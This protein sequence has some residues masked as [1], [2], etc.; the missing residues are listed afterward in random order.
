MAEIATLGP[1]ALID[2]LA[3][4][5]GIDWSRVMATRND[6]G[7]TALAILQQAY[8]AV[9]GVNQ[10]LIQRY[11]DLLYVT[12]SDTVIYRNTDGTRS[13]TPVKVDFAPNDP[14]RSGSTGHM[15][16]QRDYEDALAWSHLWLRDAR[17]GDVDADLQTITERWENRVEDDIWQ[18]VFT[19]TENAVGA[20]YDVGW[21]I[22]TGTNVNFIPSASNGETFTSAHTHFKYTGTATSA[23]VLAMVELMVKDL[24]HHGHSGNLTA[25]VSEAD[26]DT[27]VGMSKFVALQ[28]SG[29]MIVPGNGSAAVQ[30]ATATVSGM[31]GELFGYLNT[32]RGIVELRYYSRIPT[33]YIFI[34]KS[35]GNNNPANGLALRVHRSTPFGLMPTPILARTMTPEMEM[36][37]LRA[38]HGVGVNKRLNG[39]AGYFLN[40]ASSYVNPSFAS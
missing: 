34:T 38:T 35:Y 22:G 10:A 33:G 21:A 16:P 13:K 40:A 1:H 6:Q 29:F 17:Q 14:I 36:V 27:Y 18:R 26:V 20:G 25:F 39:V 12:N 2:N 30:V 23:G 3:T 4:Y 5:T 37:Q 11:G 15:L 8:A 28:P 31:P 32:S 24:R 9:G 19:T 7:L